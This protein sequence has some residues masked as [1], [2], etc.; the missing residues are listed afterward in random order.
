MATPRLTAEQIAQVSGFVARYITEQRER[1]APRASL[2]LRH[3]ALQ[4][5]RRAWRI[6]L[7]LFCNVSGYEAGNLGNLFGRQSWSCHA[8]MS[9]ESRETRVSDFLYTRLRGATVE[10]SRAKYRSPSAR[11]EI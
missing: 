5:K 7:A 11:S 8:A 10:R 2:Y 9:S 3:T 6:P 1:Y 4:I